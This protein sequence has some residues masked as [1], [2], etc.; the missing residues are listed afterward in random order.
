MT[1]VRM[2]AI[3]SALL[4]CCGCMDYGRKRSLYVAVVDGQGRSLDGV[5]INL[6]P[7]TP[8][9][10]MQKEYHVQTCSNGVAVLKYHQLWSNRRIPPQIT[11]SNSLTMDLFKVE[12]NS[13]AY[14]VI[15]KT[16][17]AGKARSLS[18][19]EFENMLKGAVSDLDRELN[20]D[21]RESEAGAQ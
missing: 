3:L 9:H 14:Y 7:D 1:D 17:G 15:M 21:F 19:G 10:P 13:E 8:I 2:M 18:R 20:E 12:D 11:W 16:N 6:V 4:I 5:A